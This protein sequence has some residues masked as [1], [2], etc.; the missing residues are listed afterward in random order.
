MENIIIGHMT[1]TLQRM[2]NFFLD[3]LIRNTSKI[4]HLEINLLLK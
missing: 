3:P 2:P 1:E 4:K